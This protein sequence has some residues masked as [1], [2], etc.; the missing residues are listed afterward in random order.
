[1][2]VKTVTSGAVV[3][4]G[5]FRAHCLRDTVDPRRNTTMT[6][7]PPVSRRPVVR[8]RTR[9]WSIAALV[10]G[11]MLAGSALAVAGT[12]RKSDEYGEMG[13]S[14]VPVVGTVSGPTSFRVSSFNVLGYDHTDG[15]KGS[16][17]GYAN[18]SMRM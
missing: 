3:D 2:F 13:P 18:G 15:G 6:A 17:K 8:S 12:D 7:L 1:M 10:V 16:K 9:V 4:L 11:T 14:P 5:S